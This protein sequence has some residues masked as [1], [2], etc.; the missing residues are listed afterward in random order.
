MLAE[1]ALPTEYAAVAP[2]IH[3]GEHIGPDGLGEGWGHPKAVA[4]SAAARDTAI[5][6]RLWTVS[7]QLTGAHYDGLEK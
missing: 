7:E 3:G 6:A 2:Q 4:C 1:R 5:A